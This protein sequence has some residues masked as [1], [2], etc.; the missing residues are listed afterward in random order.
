MIEVA[1]AWPEMEKEDVQILRIANVFLR[2]EITT[3]SL[4]W[5]MKLPVDG[6]CQKAR[7]ALL[8]EVK[9]EDNDLGEI[10]EERSKKP[11]A[12]S[13]SPNRSSTRST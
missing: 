4:M 2:K 6:I 12:G 5:P 3:K 11:A 10:L 1:L 13:R 9:I 8:K 7:D